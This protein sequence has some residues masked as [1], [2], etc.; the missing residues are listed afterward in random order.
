[1]LKKIGFTYE[2]LIRMPHDDNELK[3]FASEAAAATS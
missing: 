1:V 3:L 2:R